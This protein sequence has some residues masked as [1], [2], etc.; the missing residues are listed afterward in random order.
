MNF[1][2][3]KRITDWR[4]RQPF[5]KKIELVCEEASLRFDTEQD[6][7]YTVWQL[8]ELR[9]AMAHGQPI[10]VSTTAYTREELRTSMACTW[11]KNLNPKFVNHAYVQAKQLERTLFTNCGI[12]IGETVTSAVGIGV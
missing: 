9:D 2:G 7:L 1:I 3:H 6:P 10:E 5:M 4:E 8:K 12:K 11:D